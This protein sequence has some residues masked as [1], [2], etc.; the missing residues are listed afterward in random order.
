MNKFLIILGIILVIIAGVFF[1][2]NRPDGGFGLI[3]SNDAPKSTVKINN[4]TFKIETAT[5]S[6]ELQK[7]LS[8]RESLPKDQGLLFIFDHKDFHTFWMKNMKFPIDILFINGD[9]IVS[10]EKNAQPMK[11]ADEELPLFKPSEVADK[12]LEIN[13][14][15]ADKYEIKTGD[16]IEIKIAE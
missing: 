6:A 15:L 1:Y 11:S 14:G 4:Q 3:K 10:I 2:Q 7:G 16:K 12:V 9:E 13:S 5:T 8:G